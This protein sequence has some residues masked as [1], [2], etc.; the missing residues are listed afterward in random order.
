MQIIMEKPTTDAL[1]LGKNSFY[2]RSLEKVVDRFMKGLNTIFFGGSS[3]SKFDRF[4][5]LLSAFFVLFFVLLF[6]TLINE[7]QLYII[8]IFGSIDVNMPTK[9]RAL[10]NISIET[11][12]VI[13]P[14]LLLFY[15]IIY[16]IL[17]GL[18]LLA[19][20]LYVFNPKKRSCSIEYKYITVFIGLVIVFILKVA[21]IQLI[22]YFQ[23][24][25]IS[26]YEVLFR[27]VPLP[28]KIIPIVL[29]VLYSIWEIRNILVDKEGAKTVPEIFYGIIIGVSA[30][31]GLVQF[32]LYSLGVFY[33][34]N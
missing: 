28:G 14:I 19:V 29:V 12:T 2:L 31:S 16:C 25:A 11:K 4:K 10:T 26:I 32:I 21:L 1:S 33:T 15:K 6:F 20:F 22:N 3:S 34:L 23:T 5:S 27:V 13:D 8:S 18:P 24:V 7:W 9:T 30:F 17:H